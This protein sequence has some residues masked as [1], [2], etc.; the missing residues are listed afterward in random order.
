MAKRKITKGEV[1]DYLHVTTAYRVH[2]PGAQ[3]GLRRLIQPGAYKV[4]EHINSVLAAEIVEDGAGHF[5]DTPEFGK[6]QA[7]PAIDRKLRKKEP[8]PENKMQGAADESKT[9]D[10]SPEDTE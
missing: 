10:A 5:S 9:A 7:R 3:I 2:G 6:V 4:P 8:A 1:G